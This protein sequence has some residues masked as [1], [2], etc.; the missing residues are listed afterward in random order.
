[1]GRHCPALKREIGLFALAN[2]GY[3]PEFLFPP[4]AG[5][6]LDFEDERR[7]LPGIGEQLV[8]LELA[9][10][11]LDP[12]AGDGNPRDPAALEAPGTGRRLYERAAAPGDQALARQLVEEPKGLPERFIALLGQYWEEAFGREWERIE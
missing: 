4:P 8:R 12:R 2:R 6:L 9:I 5:E 3:F 10:P 1:M 11:F 7:R